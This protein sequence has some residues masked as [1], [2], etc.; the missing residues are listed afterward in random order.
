M[1]RTVKIFSTLLF[2]TLVGCG[3]AIRPVVPTALESSYRLSAYTVGDNSSGISIEYRCPSNPNVIPDFDGKLDGTGQYSVCT[4][5]SSKSQILI[6]PESYQNEKLCIF[7]AQV[8]DSKHV[9]VKPDTQTGG[10]WH[11][12]IPHADSGIFADF[13]GIQ[14]NAVFI[15][16]GSDEYQMT[17]CL[18]GGNYYACPQYSFGQFR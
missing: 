17:K 1:S 10:P 14:Y 18:I 13:P 12:C 9:Y 11:Q 8:I 4:H 6:Q 5:N 2:A 7:P 15:V 3:G 16:D